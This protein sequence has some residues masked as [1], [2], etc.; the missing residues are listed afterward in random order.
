LHARVAAAVRCLLPGSLKA[1]YQVPNAHVFF[2]EPFDVRAADKV[3]SSSFIQAIS[4]GNFLSTLIAFEGGASF[5]VPV[6]FTAEQYQA[7]SALAFEYGSIR[8]KD[9]PF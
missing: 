4:E 5:R 1:A 6:F 2:V 9:I 8:T 7:L 3:R